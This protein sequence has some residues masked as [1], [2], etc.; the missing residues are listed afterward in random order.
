MAAVGVPGAKAVARAVVMAVATKVEGARMVV[1]EAVREEAKQAAAA[2]VVAGREEP[3]AEASMAEK[4]VVAVTETAR[5][6]AEQAVAASV[7]A[8]KEELVARA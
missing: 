5:E 6:V 4:S 7:V 2:S 3:T 1:T 8:R